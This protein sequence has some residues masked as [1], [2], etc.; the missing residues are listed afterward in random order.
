M[1]ELPID[2]NI[3]H[4][5]AAGDE[6]EILDALTKSIEQCGRQT[7]GLRCVVSHHAEGDRDVHSGTPWIGYYT[8]TRLFVTLIPGLLRPGTHWL[9]RAATVP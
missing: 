6:G 1:D 8:P 5:A 4:S 2:N 7:D 3:K 9:S